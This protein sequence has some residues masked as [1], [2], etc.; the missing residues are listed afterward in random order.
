MSTQLPTPPPN[1][2]PTSL[3]NDLF[4][5][6]MADGHKFF[7]PFSFLVLGIQGLLIAALVLLTFGFIYV[8]YDHIFGPRKHRKQTGFFGRIWSVITSWCVGLT[9]AIFTV[10]NFA[11]FGLPQIYINRRRAKTARP[12][13]S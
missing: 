8:V 4:L 10:V 13:I 11:L 3:Q 6:F 5:A 9:R 2:P 12:Q 1:L 7:G